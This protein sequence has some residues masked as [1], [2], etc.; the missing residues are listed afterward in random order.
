MINISVKNT[1]SFG[2]KYVYYNNQSA[3]SHSGRN[4][5]CLIFLTRYS[6]LSLIFL[7]MFVFIKSG[8]K[9]ESR[10][11]LKLVLKLFNLLYH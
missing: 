9:C 11:V 5:A 4:L 8:S 6:L 1:V 7:S 3:F 10:K 2:K